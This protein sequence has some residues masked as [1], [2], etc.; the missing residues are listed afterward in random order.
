MTGCRDEYYDVRD[1]GGGGGV[2]DITSTIGDRWC[3]CFELTRGGFGG[4]FMGE[5]AQGRLTV[6]DGCSYGGLSGNVICFRLPNVSRSERI[7]Y[8]SW[9]QVLPVDRFRWVD[10]HEF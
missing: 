6:R 8:R 10:K 1:G 4:V 9:H 2:G 5:L 7:L 3:F